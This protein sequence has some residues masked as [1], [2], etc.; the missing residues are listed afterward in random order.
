[1]AKAKRT[2]I[3]CPGCTGRRLPKWMK[4]TGG[5]RKMWVCAECNGSGLQT[6]KQQRMNAISEELANR[7]K[8][9]TNK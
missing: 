6:P 7:F 5:A 9:A 2:T 4:E 1:M 8:C 3:P